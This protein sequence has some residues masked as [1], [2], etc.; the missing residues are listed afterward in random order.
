[1]SKIP[2]QAQTIGTATTFLAGGAFALGTFL[3]LA[4]FC[5]PEGRGLY[6]I[7]RNNL[8]MIGLFYVMLMVVLHI[9]AFVMLVVCLIVYRQ[10]PTYFFIRIGVLLLNI[11]VAIFYTYFIISI[12]N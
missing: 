8:I 2:I 1:M 3:L 7:T 10:Q 5:I 4:Y 6:G 9:I 11:P 12:Q